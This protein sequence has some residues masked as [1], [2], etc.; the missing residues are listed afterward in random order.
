MV[1]F[2][3]KE[4]VESPY[5]TCVLMSSKWFILHQTHHRLAETPLQF[6]LASVLATLKAVIMNT[7]PGLQ[8]SCMYSNLSEH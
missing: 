3:Q 5:R 4:V 7:F 8:C 1:L 6:S 2:V